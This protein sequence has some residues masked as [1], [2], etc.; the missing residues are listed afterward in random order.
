M[1]ASSTSPVSAASAFSLRVIDWIRSRRRMRPG[2]RRAPAGPHPASR[3]ATAREGGV[4]R[5]DDQH[6]LV[7]GDQ[8]ADRVHDGLR[9]AGA[10]QRVDGEVVAGRDLG[11]D[12]LLLRVRVEQ[13]ARRAAGGR[14]SWRIS[15]TR[16]VAPRDARDGGRVAG[17]GVDHRV[18]EVAGRRRAARAPTSAN[19]EMSRRGCTLNRCRWRGQLAQPVDHRLRLEGPCLQRERHERVRVELDVVLLAHRRDEPRVQLQRAL[20]PQLEVAAVA[21]DRER[22]QQ[23]GA[24]EV[25]LLEPPLGEADREVHAVHA[26]CGGEL[27]GLRG[28]RGGRGARGAEGEVVADQVRQQ[29][30]LAGDELREAGRDA[31]STARSGCGPSPRSGSAARS[32]PTC[33]ELL[34]PPLPGADGAV[35]GGEAGVADAHGVR[36]EASPVPVATR[37]AAAGAAPPSLRLGIQHAATVGRGLRPPHR[38]HAAAW[39]RQ[40]RGAGGRHWPVPAPRPFGSASRSRCD[41]ATCPSPALAAAGAVEAKRWPFAHSTAATFGSVAHLPRTVLAGREDLRRPARPRRCQPARARSRGSCAAAK[42]SAILSPAVVPAERVDAAEPPGP[43][44]R[45]VT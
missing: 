41:R 40:E 42:P 3:P 28:E 2:R 15:S 22:A 39:R 35:H 8:R 13:R 27:D 33:T 4:A 32:P 38:R 5:A 17:D 9:R 7:L 45:V 10:G 37:G 34:P 16:S 6:A 30:R 25:L 24:A 20:Q 19:E 26:P 31:S 21:A 43:A 11:D 23:H 12:L 29:R 44:G 1:R 14:S 36:R 18:R